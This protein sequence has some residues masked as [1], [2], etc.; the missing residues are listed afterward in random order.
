MNVCTYYMYYK[1]NYLHTSPSSDYNIRISIGV[2]SLKARVYYK[3]VLNRGRAGIYYYFET[4]SVFRRSFLFSR[5]PS[6]PAQMPDRDNKNVQS[7]AYAECVLDYTY[8]SNDEFYISYIFANI[9][10]RMNVRSSNSLGE[11][12][13]L[14]IISS[15]L[16][17]F[18]MPHFYSNQLYFEHSE[19]NARNVLI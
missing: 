10:A 7:H 5:P 19:N 16:T 3:G 11:R 15:L 14:N 6:I 12:F 8:I 17:L 2:K 13:P 18:G 9:R 1:C 4:S